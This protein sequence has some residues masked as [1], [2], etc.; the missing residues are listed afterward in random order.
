MSVSPHPPPALPQIESRL[1]FLQESI[2]ELEE[3]LRLRHEQKQA[4]LDELD[5]KICG[6]QTSIHALEHM[7][8]LR[9]PSLMDQRRMHLEKEVKEL[10]REKRQQKQEYWRDS[11]ALQKEL[12][13][14][15]KE[16]RAAQSSAGAL[17]L[18]Q[19]KL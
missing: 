14:L 11:I 7:G 12:R 9:S 16:Y 5:Q 13:L 4:M 15:K 2:S 19:K 17:C 6:V 1:K 8:N 3:Q 10:E 18:N